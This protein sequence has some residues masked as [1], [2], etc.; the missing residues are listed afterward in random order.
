MDMTV[1]SMDP[2][3]EPY[4]IVLGNQKGGT[5]KTT[6]AVHMAIALQALGLKVGCLDLDA[7]QRSLTR[8]LE[9][10]RDYAAAGPDL[11]VPRFACVESSKAETQVS[12]D[13]EEAENLKH[14]LAAMSDCQVLV[15]D[16]AGNDLNLARLAHREADTLVT[17]INDSF[18]DIDVIGVVDPVRKEIQGPSNYAKMVWEQNNLR[19]IDGRPPIDWVVLRNRLTFIDARNKREMAQVLGL[20]AQR[21]GFRIVPG[22]GERVIYRELFL[23]GLTVFD[24]VAKENGGDGNV[25]HDRARQEIRNLLQVVSLMEPAGA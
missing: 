21:I 7:R 12:R 4:V 14:A 16:T 13:A 22:L 18:L 9:N 20:L 8:Y 25:S 6:T 15:L 23:R 10:R 2:S 3:A 19:I 1:D 5:G 17:P 24:L 11:A